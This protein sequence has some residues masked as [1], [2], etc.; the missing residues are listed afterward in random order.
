[1][2]SLLPLR[3]SKP[4][5]F[6]LAK[7]GAEVGSGNGNLINNPTAAA[8]A[9]GLGNGITTGT[10][11]GCI[12]IA[13]A[14][15]SEVRKVSF[16]MAVKFKHGDA[17]QTFQA[18]MKVGCSS[19]DD[20][21]RVIQ[22]LDLPEDTLA[23]AVIGS[24][25]ANIP[26]SSLPQSILVGGA[27][28]NNYAAMLY[29]RYGPLT[30]INGGDTAP[31]NV[32]DG[33]FQIL[34]VTFDR[35][36]EDDADFFAD[37]DTAAAEGD[38]AYVAYQS[39]LAV[40][41][42]TW[43]SADFATVNRVLVS[44]QGC[45]VTQAPAAVN[46]SCTVLAIGEDNA[47]SA[48]QSF[49]RKKTY[50][51]FY[52]DSNKFNDPYQF[53]YNAA[54]WDGV[55][56]ITAVLRGDP[57][58]ANV[59]DQFQW[60]FQRV[61]PHGDASEILLTG[62]L[63]GAQLSNSTTPH[64]SFYRTVDLLPFMVDGESYSFEWIIPDSIG[65]NNTGMGRFPFYLEVIQKNLTKTV[66]LFDVA[67][68]GAGRNIVTG[69]QSQAGEE[70]APPLA[71]TLMLNGMGSYFDP[72]WFANMP[73]EFFTAR[74]FWA[75][76]N[77]NVDESTIMFVKHDE[78][79]DSRDH[80]P[81]VA[82][83]ALSMLPSISGSGEP[84][85]M[86][87][88]EQSLQ[89]NDPLNFSTPRKMYTRNHGT[90]GAAFAWMGQAVIGY[91][92]SVPSTEILTEGDLFSTEPF[93]PEGC[94][95][96]AAGLGTPATLIITNGETLPARFNPNEGTVTTAGIPTPY[97]G[98]NPS[99]VVDEVGGSPDNLGLDGGTY[100]YRYTFRDCCT[101]REGNPNPEAIFVTVSVSIGLKGRVTFDFSDVRIPGDTS[102][103]EI[104]VYRTVEGGAYPVM[105]KVG[106]FDP[107]ETTVFVDELNDTQLDFTN[108]GLSILNDPPP[109]CPYI[110]GLK[111]RLWMA[112]D[113]PI[114]LPTGTVSVTQGSKFVIG[115]D[116]VAW[117]RCL[118]GKYL[119]VGDDC[120]A[121]EIDQVL[122]PEDGNSPPFGRLMLVTEYEGETRLGQL[123]TVCGDPNS[124]YNTEPN[125]PEYWPRAAR[126]R[127]E[128]GDGDRITGLGTNYDRLIITKRNKC[129]AYSFYQNPTVEG[130]LPARISS[131]I[132]GIAPRSFAQVEVGTVWLADRGLALFDGRGVQHVP[133]SV[134][135][136]G[137]F[138]DPDHPRYVRRN[139]NG[140]VVDAVGIFY[141]K[142]EFYLLLLPTVQT[143]RG[144]NLM[145]C[146][147]V[148]DRN[149][150]LFE[151]CQEFQSMALAKD[152]D[153]NQIV[154]LGDVNGFVWAFDVGFTD[155]IGTPG[156]TGTLRGTLT[157][158]GVD[159][160]TALSYAEDSSAT[161][162]QGGLLSLADGISGVIGGLTPALAGGL[163]MAGACIAVRRSRS[164]PWVTRT[165]WLSTENRIYVSP[166]WDSTYTPEAGWEYMLGAIFFEAV[167][168]PQNY[169]T[170]D[171]TKRN[172]KQ[173]L[174]HEP[175][176][177]N[178]ELMVELLPDF[179]DVDQFEGDIIS[180]DAGDLEGRTFLM[181]Q[182][183]GKQVR[184]IEKV[185]HTY[186]GVR[187]TNFAP[188]EPIR[189]I[190]H[191]IT[192][193]ARQ[194]S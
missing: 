110:V 72:A 113:I 6:F 192:T 144:C 191:A 22:T 34:T 194:E 169:G 32:V 7:Q 19:S 43:D 190:N 172:W 3:Y 62:S 179:S 55:Q 21:T 98:E 161:F 114:L 185:V 41:L 86:V 94:A 166:S 154:Y 46:N 125:E 81:D 177:I 52:V 127:V 104:C 145:L 146:W 181:D 66:S 99:G 68:P 82:A 88:R 117:D 40:V 70:E 155:G 59:A 37:W 24:G 175:E 134:A 187:M 170:D 128:P 118:E 23:T 105:A 147:N 77:N 53:R 106:C 1:M 151:F 80:T 183:F 39:Y 20:D 167:F 51:T 33:D 193:T 178:S 18:M 96:M 126:T 124:V 162:I 165:I 63:T 90:N 56:K 130:G 123:Y 141:P 11:H 92:Y 49:V 158:G 182:K 137:M 75:S 61:A 163:G 36:D 65:G 30:T 173:V 54:D 100:E 48:L 107:D 64:N 122:P 38:D 184:R 116:D 101:G 76:V 13:P 132:G 111:N 186:L 91:S 28:N 79:L 25:R 131:D 180:N 140:I 69:D 171:Y 156:A 2:V 89:V 108:D 148:K 136:N 45:V 83:G 73:D 14:R 176:S 102:V 188:E 139:Q 149:I 150:T 115:D 189:I 74:R 29:S 17:L 26:W 5:T 121:Y 133:E 152:E 42:S 78:D 159:A 93:N 160:E 119:K 95:A 47:I 143:T 87:W 120:M 129:Y 71:N 174:I 103:C 57:G 135:M 85:E 4:H 67:G 112:G 16:W 9:D 35:A 10:L 15:Y 84:T 157:G 12:H 153:G 8:A 97:F 168:K 58:A 142:R 138:V 164:D 60:R 44:A 31:Q 50:T 109:C 27:A